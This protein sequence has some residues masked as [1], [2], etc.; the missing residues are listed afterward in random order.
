MDRADLTPDLR[1]SKLAAAPGPRLTRSRSGAILDLTHAQVSLTGRKQMS[2]TVNASLDDR[3]AAWF[4][5]DP[6]A[7]AEGDA[8]WREVRETAPVYRFGATTLITRY[9]LVKELVHDNARF[10]SD[11][12]RKGS[13]ADAA[14]AALT[15]DEERQAFREVM[16]FESHF[17]NRNDAPEHRRLRGSASAALTP[18]RVKQVT[19]AIEGHA[20]ASLELLSGAGE[21]VVDLIPFSYEL[22]L[23]VICDL[24]GVPAEDRLKIRD[25]G[26]A[27]SKN[28]HG[29][30]AKELVG[31]YHAWLEFLEYV[32]HLIERY[33]ASADGADQ[34]VTML[35]NAHG[36]DRLDPE[37]IASLFVMLLQGGHETTSNL[38]AIGTYHLLR[39][40]GQWQ[41]LVDDPSLIP[42]AVE[43]L[44]RYVAPAQTASRRSL[45]DTEIEGVEIRKEDTVIGSLTAA[46]RDPAVFDDPEAVDV[47]RTDAKRHL[48]FSFGPHFCLGASLA[49]AEANVALRTLTQAFPNLELP[50]ED[51]EWDG[52]WNLRRIVELP[53]SLGR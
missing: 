10:S 27:L 31:S 24:I 11:H 43:E 8:M 32:A 34:L 4:D 13:R 7:I 26:V 2:S 46:N 40:P 3:L 21:D 36:T 41:A 48:A 39:T 37:E 38:I 30:K 29:T 14:F 20:Q 42:N 18:R 9:D 51:V 44:L 28:R 49:R 25:W 15:T 1:G 16:R 19:D 5:G 12:S 23:R 17:M 33:Q 47:R 50:S 45:V 52:P 35:M 53:V 22:P 6:V